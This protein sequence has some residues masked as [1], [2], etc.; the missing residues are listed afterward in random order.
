MRA[1]PKVDNSATVG[2]IGWPA[3]PFFGAQSCTS[4]LFAKLIVTRH[5][6]CCLYEALKSHTLRAFVLL[7]MVTSMGWVSAKTSGQDG[8]VVQNPEL[9]AELVAYAPRGI[10]AGKPFSLGLLLEHQPQWHT[11]WVNPG[12]SG[13]PTELQWT[14]PTGAQVGAIDWPVPKKIK[15]GTLANLGYEGRVL[16]PVPVQFEKG[17]NT[18]S[19]S[20]TVRLHAT[21][22]VCRQECI[23][24]EGDFTLAIP[25]QGSTALHSDLFEAA[26]QKRPVNFGGQVQSEFVPEGLVL[27]LKGLPQGWQGK[28]IA[29]FPEA[30][31]V[32]ASPLLPDP[33][34]MVASSSAVGDKPL[35][36]ATQLWDGDTWA[37]LFPFSPQ[38]VGGPERLTFLLSY[39]GNSV[40]TTVGAP[41]NWPDNTG[42]API[43]VPTA[44]TPAI[45]E[46]GGPDIGTG[47]TAVVFSG[48]V[49]AALVGGLLLNLMPCVFPVLALKALGLASAQG[50]A[51]QRSA[52]AAAYTG[53]VL[54][55]MG[56]L[57]G[58]LLGLR[59]GGQA[60]GWGFHLQSP[61]FIAA[62]ATLFTLI[63][64]NLMD[65]LDVSRLVPSRLAG[66]QLHNPVTDAA[67]SGVLAVVV[68]SPCTAPFM[69]AS[70]GLAMTLPSWQAMM[71]F[72]ALGLGLALPYALVTNS[73]ALARQLPKPGPWMEQLRRFMV[74]PMAAT[75][76]WLVW[77]FAHM[78]GLDVAAILVAMLLCMSM[79]LWALHLPGR[80]ALAFGSV[81]LLLSLLTGG[82][83]F[84]V[85]SQVDTTTL[86]EQGN[87]G[88]NVWRNWTPQAA[89]E[90]LASGH[91]VFV[92]F[93]AAWCITCQYNE[94][95]VLS[96]LRVQQAFAEKQVV[97]LR[98]D[99]TKRDAAISQALQ[100]LGRSG[101]PVYVLLRAGRAPVLMS[102]LLNTE[103]LLATISAI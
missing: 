8:S 41:G 40:H 32:F 102:E 67:L 16:I 13:L 14:L 73:Q 62:L 25:L 90:A 87:K 56:V 80:A 86:S 76:L 53:G 64:L 66:M 6:I 72:V 85:A 71:I 70:L 9:R 100:Q 54:I 68:A 82:L 84:R 5:L 19:D 18:S 63:C 12:D 77:V 48:A 34:D 26:L 36:A 46:S 15:I 83:A 47:A 21:W 50:S 94:Q 89:Q 61:T 27:R 88:A 92:D 51:N 96:K 38:R 81:A 22:L 17:F 23:P 59:A 69:G 93:T 4:F 49:L 78:T 3:Y 31:S 74:F 65:L 101:V 35:A 24:Q 55:S 58:L 37:A 29:A 99:W 1:R 28:A 45:G 2:G 60:L 103:E 57:G 43:T 44:Q 33:Q 7:L 95:H 39:G 10:G 11:Y 98:A 75:V 91:P 97:L 30:P 52:Q 20:L 79:C 42:K